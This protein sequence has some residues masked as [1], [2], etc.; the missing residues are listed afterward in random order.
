MTIYLLAQIVAAPPKQRRI[1]G[2]AGAAV[3]A[4]KDSSR[5]A[6]RY[7]LSLANLL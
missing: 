7:Y 6:C 3:P 1:H 2:P 4:L 5:C